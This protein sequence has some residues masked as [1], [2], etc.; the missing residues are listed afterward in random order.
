MIGAQALSRSVIGAPSGFLASAGA[1][2]E[3]SASEVAIVILIGGVR[4]R[5]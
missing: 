2:S 5:S 3:L 1:L 4:A